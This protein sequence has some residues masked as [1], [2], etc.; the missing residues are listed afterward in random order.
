M[1]IWPSTRVC[2]LSSS[3]SLWGFPSIVALFPPHSTIRVFRLTLPQTSLL[4]LNSWYNNQVQLFLFYKL[5]DV[6]IFSKQSIKVDPLLSISTF[7]HFSRIELSTN[8]SK[9][10]IKEEAEKVL[11]EGSSQEIY[12][13]ITKKVQQVVL[14]YLQWWFVWKIAALCT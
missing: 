12:I 11:Y 10:F 14:K 3:Q 2:R 13:P 9:N 5:T 8:S 4:Q 1:N 7:K 6:Y